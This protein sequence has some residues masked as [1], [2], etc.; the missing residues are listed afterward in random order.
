MTPEEIDD[1]LRRQGYIAD[2]AT[3]KILQY[4]CLLD[5][6]LLVEGP[7]GAGKTG[8]AKAWSRVLG[9]ELIRLQCYEGINRYAFYNLVNATMVKA[10][11]GAGFVMWLVELYLGPDLERARSRYGASGPPVAAG[12]P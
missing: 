9:R 5:K 3:V 6:P 4:A 1:G 11:W 2:R 8:L 12:H 7:A 10:P